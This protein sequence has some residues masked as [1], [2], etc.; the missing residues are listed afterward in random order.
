MKKFFTDAIG[1]AK[2]DGSGTSAI[3]D[4]FTHFEKQDIFMEIFMQLFAT[5]LGDVLGFG[6]GSFLTGA[7]VKSLLSAPMRALTKFK[8]RPPPAYGVRASPA[9]Y[10][11]PG[12]PPPYTPI[13]PKVNPSA[14]D[15]N[16]PPATLPKD[17]APGT[18]PPTAFSKIIN[19]D[20]LTRLTV[21]SIFASVL[22]EVPSKPMA[23][24]TGLIYSANPAFESSD[25]ILGKISATLGFNSMMNQMSNINVDGMTQ[26]LKDMF[27]GDDLSL[28]KISAMMGPDMVNFVP[29][30]DGKPPQHLSTAVKTNRLQ[31]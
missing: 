24:V 12:P 29:K 21:G 11:G 14:G 10:N 13:A 3:L 8:P 1:W 16:L 25:G 15:A 17:V 22:R 19:G 27:S 5:L 4:A 7:V 23:D 2:S 6:V 30:P 26:N 28:E 18:N 20:M 31:G 9:P